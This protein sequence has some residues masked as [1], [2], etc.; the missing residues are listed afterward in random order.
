MIEGVPENLIHPNE[1]VAGDPAERMKYAFED[2]LRN[3]VDSICG[4]LN[5]ANSIAKQPE[6]LLQLLE[7]IW[8]EKGGKLVRFFA[9]LNPL[10]DIPSEVIIAH[11]G[12]L[13][14]LAEIASTVNETYG[15]IRPN[16]TAEALHNA[17]SIIIELVERAKKRI[18]H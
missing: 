18:I 3:E 17:S 11:Q 12:T 6:F 1:A 8:S 7:G 15:A 16:P 5:P 9:E 14:E 13:D 2:Y 4:F 10:D